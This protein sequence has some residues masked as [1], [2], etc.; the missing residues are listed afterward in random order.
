MTKKTT[1]KKLKDCIEELN[2]ED[3]SDNVSSAFL[4]IFVIA[5]C[6]GI[7]YMAL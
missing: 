5:L 6:S 7:L 1:M 4:L 3:V 2:Q